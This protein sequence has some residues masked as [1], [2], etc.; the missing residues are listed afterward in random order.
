M[1]NPHLWS[2][3]SATPY[4]P[5]MGLMDACLQRSKNSPLDISLNL[6]ASWGTVDAFPWRRKYL[7]C[8]RIF[9]AV[10]PQTSRWRCLHLNFVDAKDL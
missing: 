3:I 5:E 6:Y 1:E 9:S 8:D 2:E 4:K 10:T 7:S